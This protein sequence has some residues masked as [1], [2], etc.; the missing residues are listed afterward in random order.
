M[1]KD[2]GKQISRR[3][4]SFFAFTYIELILC[5]AKRQNFDQPETDPRA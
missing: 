3:C 4:I 1:C 2:I 5:S